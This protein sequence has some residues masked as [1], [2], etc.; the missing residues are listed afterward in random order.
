VN[1]D[2]RTPDILT[3][4][5]TFIDALFMEGWEGGVFSGRHEENIIKLFS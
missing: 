3:M 5:E 1:G 4:V 2:L